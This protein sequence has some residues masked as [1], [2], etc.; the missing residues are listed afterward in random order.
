MRNSRKRS[1]ALRDLQPVRGNAAVGRRRGWLLHVRQM[2]QNGAGARREARTVRLRRIER[3]LP[4][5]VHIGAWF[6]Q[7]TSPAPCPPHVPETN[8]AALTSSRTRD[9]NLVEITRR[10]DSRES[11]RWRGTQPRDNEIMSA[12]S[13]DKARFN[14]L[15]KQKIARRVRNRVTTK[16]SAPTAV[17]SAR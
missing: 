14:R 15:R 9:A 4:I 17:A 12:R 16:L 8:I 7:R 6:S 11:G 2:D 10:G 1:S 13:G 3:P 5:L